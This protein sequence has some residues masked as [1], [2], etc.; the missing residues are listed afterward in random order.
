MWEF[1]VRN[2]ETGEIT[3]I[4]GYNYSDACRRWKLVPN[5]WEILLQTYVD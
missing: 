1:E 4:F 5:E 2:Y 3:L